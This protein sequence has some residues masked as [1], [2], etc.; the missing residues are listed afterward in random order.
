MKRK[1]ARMQ[2]LV[3]GGDLLEKE[4][5]VHEKEVVEVLQEGE[6]Y[7]GVTEVEVQ[8]EVGTSHRSQVTELS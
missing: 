3:A 1:L 2:L 7:E 5:E 4:Q 6:G 8:E